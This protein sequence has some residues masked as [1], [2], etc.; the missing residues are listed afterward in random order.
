VVFERTLHRVQN[1]FSINSSKTRDFIHSLVTIKFPVCIVKYLAYTS[2]SRDQDG[3]TIKNIFIASLDLTGAYIK[4]VFP[5][6]YCVF[7]VAWSCFNVGERAQLSLFPKNCISFRDL[8]F[9]DFDTFGN[10]E[11]L[12]LAPWFNGVGLLDRSTTISPTRPAA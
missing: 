2:L 4:G 9:Q 1:K 3:L 6:W 12:V 5:I 11:S 10:N 8:N 7:C